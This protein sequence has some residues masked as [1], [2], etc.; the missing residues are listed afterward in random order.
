MAGIDANLAW[1]VL[2]FFLVATLYSSVGFGG[3]SSYLAIL[4]LFLPNFLEIKQTALL[5][6]LVVVSGGTY[7]FLKEGYLDLKRFLPLTLSSVP[8]AF[9][10]A[11][12]G[13]SQEVFFFLLGL[14]LALS[15][16]LLLAQY[17]QKPTP[18]TGEQKSP[19]WYLNLLLGGATGFLAGLVG[20]GGGILLAP[21]LH[22]LK[23][24]SA[25]SIA[26]L[27]SFFI[28][29]NSVSGLL[30]MVTSGKFQ[31]NFTLLA[32]LLLAVLVGG[33]LGTRLSLYT[34]Q[35]HVIKGL[36]GVFVLY[37]GVK[38]VIDYF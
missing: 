19:S 29:V 12:V 30:G 4:T 23:W 22:L 26:A 24:G 28:L 18:E 16:L 36:T 13:L 27:A 14:V 8:A 21:L 10:G 6:N 9:L 15:G 1:L 33:Q 7:L 37:I 38:L 3:G 34:F 20:I 17:A 25:R 11:T 32:P 35:P 5:C 2:C 31:A